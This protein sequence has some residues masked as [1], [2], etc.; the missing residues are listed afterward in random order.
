M[1]GTPWH[2]RPFSMVRFRMTATVLRQPYTCWMNWLEIWLLMTL[3][4]LEA[5]VQLRTCCRQ[6]YHRW[7]TI[8]PT[9]V[10]MWLRQCLKTFVHTTGNRRWVK[11]MER[12][13]SWLVLQDDLEPEARELGITYTQYRIPGCRRTYFHRNEHWSLSR[14][15]LQMPWSEGTRG[16]RVRLPSRERESLLQ[17][18]RAKTFFKKDMK[19]C[20]SETGTGGSTL[21]KTG[22]GN[23]S[24][25]VTA[26]KSRHFDDKR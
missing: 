18:R 3:L 1:T 17:Q 5:L 13:D 6:G 23:W 4:D 11:R 7:V 22:R 24:K 8:D 16:R 10:R 12:D 20:G 25:T 21:G 26:T 2:R 15:T 19:L 9:L 14:P